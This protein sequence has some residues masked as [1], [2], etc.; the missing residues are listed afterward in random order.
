MTEERSNIN[1]IKIALVTTNSTHASYQR[2]MREMERE[3]LHVIPIVVDIDKARYGYLARVIPAANL[4]LKMTMHRSADIYWAWGLDAALVTTLA[5]AI[6]K[7][8]V[9]WDISDLIPAQIEPS[10]LGD[11]LIRKIE[12]ALYK[13]C[14]GLTVTSPT[15]YSEYYRHLADNKHHRVIENLLENNTTPL[16][17]TR[18][19]HSGPLRVVYAGIFRSD[20]LLTLIRD[21]ATSMPDSVEFHLHGTISKEVRGSVMESLSRIPNISLHGAYNDPADIDHIYRSG[22]V[23]FGLVDTNKSANERILMPNRFYHAGLYRLPIITTQGSEVA[24]RVTSLGVGL[25]IENTHA[26]F[27]DA[28]SFLQQSGVRENISERFPPSS[29][30]CY[31]DEYIMFARTI[32]QRAASLKPRDI[33]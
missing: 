15:F 24:A 16:K 5:K 18:P 11:Q 32:L 3:G 23:V 20:N 8:P 12:L 25:S 17:K 7:K 9:I 14:D 21:A 28:L 19:R 33:N 30:F 27:C 4:L 29:Y 22:D 31:N 2:R 26:A 1:K 10:S 6:I 13:Y